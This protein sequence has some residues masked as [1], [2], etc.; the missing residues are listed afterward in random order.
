MGR[1][2]AGREDRFNSIFSAPTREKAS[3]G[4]AT[5]QPN[6]GTHG[7]LRPERFALPGLPA[8]RVHERLRAGEIIAPD[9]A[10]PSCERMR[11]SRGL[12]PKAPSA[13]STGSQLRN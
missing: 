4:T 9:S 12:T 6:Q 13:G 2:R 7:C 11:S 10:G 5:L 1:N 3:T 8:R